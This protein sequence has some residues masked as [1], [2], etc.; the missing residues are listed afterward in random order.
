MILVIIFLVLLIAFFS[1]AETA[2]FS[3]SSY[4][5]RSYEGDKDEKR[6]LVAKLLKKPKEL[7]VTILIMAVL[8]SILVQNSISSLG[9]NLFVKV[10]LPIFLTLF[11]GEIIPKSIT[12]LNNKL[13]AK[14]SAPLILLVMKLLSPLRV[15]ITRVTES[16]S[17][18]LF[19][20]LK[21][22]PTLSNEEIEHML[23][24]SKE[25]EVISHYEHELIRGCF[26]LSSHI[27]REYMIP[28]QEAYFYLIK[29]PLE[30]LFSLFRSG[31]R[32]L[33]VTEKDLDSI[34]GVI[35]LKRF[36]FYKDRI[37]TEEKL[38]L[39][40]STPLFLPDT[41]KAFS[42]L[43]QLRE[44]D[45]DLAIVVDEYGSVKGLVLK[46][47]LIRAVIGEEEISS[48]KYVRLG[49]NAIV[50][51]GR[52]EIVEFENLFGVEID[53]S[54]AVTLGGFLTEKLGEIPHV[55]LRYKSA[56]FIFYVLSADEK[57]VD[58]IYVRRLK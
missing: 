42:A 31:K 37:T 40:L 48:S 52:M 51:N 17:D 1:A 44:R 33:V 41:T 6:R 18:F 19:F 11:L 22:V 10:V 24:M 14:R 8:C 50:A 23:G 20:F 36:F 46:E 32:S 9:N 2:L 56:G 12:L 29:S 53:K 4:T 5:L 21:K 47:D 30:E 13:V 43:C 26:N 25:K 35:T 55:G 27:L 45:D 28:K 16:I 54:K 58:K 3:I 57:K 49:R 34:L 7:L 38:R 15:V 39:F